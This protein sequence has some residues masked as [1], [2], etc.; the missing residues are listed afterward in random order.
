MSLPRRGQRHCGSLCEERLALPRLV[1]TGSR[2]FP[3]ALQQPPPQPQ[4]SPSAQPVV[5]LWKR[6]SE[7]AKTAERW[8]ENKWERALQ[9]QPGPGRRSGRRCSRCRSGDSQA[10]RG[11]IQSRQIVPEGTV[12]PAELMLEQI[13][14][15]GIVT[16]GRCPRWSRVKEQQ[17]G[18]VTDRPQPPSARGGTQR[19]FDEGKTERKTSSGLQVTKKLSRNC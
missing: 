19:T 1:P 2:R 11:G 3:P 6:I 13:F 16:R 9:T 5:P 18:A 4:L 17:R 7:R 12:S 10:G 14:P 8:G 15:Q